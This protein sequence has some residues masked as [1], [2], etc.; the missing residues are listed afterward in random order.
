MQ[1]DV[2]RTGDDGA[3]IR[4]R[5]R[6]TG[7]ALAEQ[8]GEVARLIG[9]AAYRGRLL[10]DMAATEF[11]DSSG[12]GWLLEQHRQCLRGGGML[13]LHSIPPMVNRVVHL[14][15]LHRAFHIAADPATARTYTEQRP[16]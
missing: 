11:L 10:V 1:Y 16:T 7:D 13:V 5:G 4:L 14:M 15:N 8:A 6:I 9:D 3:E 2:V 12:I